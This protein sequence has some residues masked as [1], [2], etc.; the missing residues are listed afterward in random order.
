MVVFI[1]YAKLYYREMMRTEVP[2]VFSCKFVLI[3]HGSTE[4]LV[5]SPRDFTKYHADIVERFCFDN[6]I[7][8][9]YDG[10]GKRYDI[11]DRAWS[12]LGGG[13]YEINAE[14]KSIRLYD[15]SMAYGKFD[16][17]TIADQILSFAEFRGFSV[18]IE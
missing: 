16:K 10:E 12:V 2:S 14:K 15:D 4:Y 3:R 17:Q 13:K 6:G 11:I 8:G 18:V 9:T 5:F 7:E 1:D